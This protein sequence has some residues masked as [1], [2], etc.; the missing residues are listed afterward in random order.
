[1]LDHMVELGVIAPVAEVTEWAAPL[2]VVRKA[3]GK[4]RFCVDHTRLNRHVLRPAYPTRTRRDAVA[5]VDSQASFYSSLDATDGYYQ[6]PLHRSSQHPTTFMTPWGRFK[7]LRASMGLISSGDEFSRRADAAFAGVSN[8]VRVVDDRLRFDRPFAEHVDG[9]YVIVAVARKAGITFSRNKFQFAE[10]TIAWVGFK[11]QKG[12]V[13]VDLAKL[14][15]LAEFP[16]PTKL[17]ELRSF[18]GLT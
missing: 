7:F 12:G 17:T 13:S 3:K 1:M 15:A 8:M 6:I 11:V 4:L 5:E 2:V 16:Q 18:L 9:V 10:P 14:Q